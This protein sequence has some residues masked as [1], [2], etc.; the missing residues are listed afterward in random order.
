QPFEVAGRHWL[1]GGL[2]FL[3]DQKV[4]VPAAVMAVVVVEAAAQ[5]GGGGRGQWDGGG[6]AAGADGGG[7]EGDVGGAELGAFSGGGAVQQAEQACRG[8][9]RVQRFCAGAPAAQ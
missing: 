8:F 1:C 9:V 3:A 2:A 7:G 4:R 6:P 5:R